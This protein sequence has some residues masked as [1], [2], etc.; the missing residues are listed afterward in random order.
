[1]KRKFVNYG[2][3]G[4]LVIIL[5][6]LAGT[7][8]KWKSGVERAE[9][10]SVPSALG[11]PENERET[12]NPN[13]EEKSYALEVPYHLEKEINELH[14]IDANIE[15]PEKIRTD[16]FQKAIGIEKEVPQENILKI[17][18]PFYHPQ[19]DEDADNEYMVGY[20][21][22]D[23]MSVW[24]AKKQNS[25]QMNSDTL[26]YV[27]MAYEDV[28][29]LT[30][31]NRDKYPLNADLESFSL[32]EGKEALGQILE[33]FGIQGELNITYRALDYRT[34]SEEAVELHMDGSETKPDHEWTE[35]DS[36]FYCM[37]SQAC[38]EISLV[39]AQNI[40]FYDDILNRGLNTFVLGRS[41]LFGFDISGIYDVE[42]Q[43]EYETLMDFQEIVER[44]G[45]S[46]RLYENIPTR[47]TDIS[48][49]VL[50]VPDGSGNYVMEPI[51]V[52]YGYEV[53]DYT[54][55]GTGEAVTV[56]SSFAVFIDAV[57][58]EEL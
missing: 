57:T 31:Y 56:E 16:G 44:Y 13:A 54:E 46:P 17:L 22:E 15:I 30:H 2:I 9:K 53:H 28:P 38:N 8:G 25:A 11:L 6:A 42:Y 35:E 26:G 14:S 21:G 41:R 7:N 52:F 39:S 36:C 19:K 12:E 33:Q 34:M 20:R 24:F 49:R 51:W 48:L 43:D 40:Q 47:I 55:D 50:P 18:E 3:I 4:L 1:M 58:G 45:Q 10:E 29:I 37:V 32:Q 27:D 23:N 5:L